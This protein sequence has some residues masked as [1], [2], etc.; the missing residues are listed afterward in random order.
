MVDRPGIPGDA[1]GSGRAGGSS[2]GTGPYAGAGRLEHR[3]IAD[4]GGELTSSEL[5]ER[6]K[7]I[8]SPR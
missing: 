4:A 5:A 2:G 8:F 3:F 1:G 6:L 7:R